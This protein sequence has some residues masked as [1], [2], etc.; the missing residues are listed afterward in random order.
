M[1][2]RELAGLAHHGNDPTFR[3]SDRKYP[4]LKHG[5]KTVPMDSATQF[6]LG[7]SLAGVTLAPAIGRKALLVGGVVATLPDLDVLIPI[8]NP[9][10]AMTY[11]RGPTHSILVLTA[12]APLI[13]W[14]TRKLARIPIDN[15]RRLLLTVWLCLVTHPILDALTT[16]GTQ[17]LWPLNIGPPVALPSVFIIDPFYTS[18]LLAG[19]LTMALLRNR[20]DLGHRIN[21]SLLA[22]GCLYLGLG[23]AAHFTVKAK[24]A[25]TPELKGA[26]IMV[27]PTPFNIVFWQVLAVDQDHYYVGYTS[28]LSAC[29]S[30]VMNKK[31]RV[32][33]LTGNI[34]RKPSIARLKWFTDGFY[35]YQKFGATWTIAD[36]RIGFD[37]NF[38]FRFAV[39]N[40]SAD[41]PQ[42]IEARRI[43]VERANRQAV[44]GLIDRIETGLS[45]CR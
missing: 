10:D 44:A 45:S 31:K 34:G 30:V 6:L 17:I 35:A 33:A 40:G 26:K 14:A 41:T 5:Y 7:A 36:L 20:R 29:R 3:F 37:P 38:V 2:L 12:A 24:A 22:L 39:A 32:S 15:W 28:P 11:H 23:A 8:N 21:R 18:L 19:V 1:A 9:I 13:A 27:Q 43:R 16:Y 42:P 25:A 4:N